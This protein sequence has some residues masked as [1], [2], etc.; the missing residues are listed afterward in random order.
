M[1]EDSIRCVW[2]RL[3]YQGRGG[4]VCGPRTGLHCPDAG[5]NLRSPSHEDLQ[6][7]DEACSQSQATGGVHNR[8]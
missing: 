1:S 8:P 4:G 6:T 7:C 5:R 3:R 2:T